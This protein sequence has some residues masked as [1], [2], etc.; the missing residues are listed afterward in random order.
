MNLEQL[1]QHF[2]NF[3]A[4]FT[5]SRKAAE[6]G[7]FFALKGDRF[8]GNDFAEEALRQG[9]H[10]AIVDRV[11]LKTNERCIV[12]DDVL[13]TLQQLA[14]HHRRQLTIPILGI[15]GTNGKTTT[16]ELTATVLSKKFRV[17]ATQGNLN[18]HIGVPLTLLSV[19]REHQIAIVEMG[20]NHPGEIDALCR[21]AEPDYG[22]ITNVGK[23]HLEGFGSFEGVIRTKGELYKHLT[24]NKHPV[25]VSADNPHLMGLLSPG[26]QQLTYGIHNSTAQL[27]GEI[28]ANDLHLTAKVL[29]PK[30]WL[31]IKTQLTG[32][33]NLENVLAAARIGLHFGVDPLDIRDAIE[34][35]HPQNNRSQ[36]QSTAKNQLLLDC[37]N[38]N[39]TSMEASVRNFLQIKK[40]NKILILGDMLELG[41]SSPAEHQKIV[42]L[43]RQDEVLQVVLVGPCFGKT[44][45]PDHFLK[46]ETVTQLND[47]LR[48]SDPVDQLI[49]IKGSRGIALEKCVEWL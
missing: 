23:A 36:L 12:V 21:I 43:L 22:L 9:A 15:T 19:T 11:E 14:R 49:L 16:K 31:Y 30:G 26:D 17:L 37:Y 3:P 38:A 10:L 25:F 4:A 6:G 46:F 34:E 7:L 5:D 35:Y 27:K 29:F 8:D 13:T 48:Q 47:Y 28:A 40:S 32:A 39:P 1:Y 20:A 33:Y 18:N 41:T 24:S 45:V 42:D 44:N 2:L